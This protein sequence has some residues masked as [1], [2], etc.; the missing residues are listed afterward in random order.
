MNSRRIIAAHKNGRSVVAEDASAPTN[1]F[2]SV[3]GFDPAVIWGTPPTPTIP[4]DGVDVAKA[5]STVMP[6]VGG[7]R[8]FVVTFPPDSVMA[9]PTF[10]PEAAGAEYMQRL[11]GLAEL[12]EPDCPGMHT[13]DTID[14]DIVLDGKI[15]VEFDDGATVDLSKGDI[16]VQYGTRHAWRNVSSEPATMI[17]V[18]IGASRG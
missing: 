17:F 15:S 12:F 5:A 1:L 3:P 14:Y 2:D 13:S 8:L 16:L 9:E 4:W 7:T 18:L 11:P 6:Q 10:D